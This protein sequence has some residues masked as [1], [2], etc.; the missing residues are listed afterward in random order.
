M[1]KAFGVVLIFAAI[2]I[3]I[4]L[5]MAQTQP[6][7]LE[8]KIWALLDNAKAVY[9]SLGEADFR[10]GG[11]GFDLPDG[12]RSVTELAEKAPGGAFDR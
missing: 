10:A 5:T 11:A 7:N 2:L 4:G 9:V 12:G 1:N 3:P 6:Q 8:Q